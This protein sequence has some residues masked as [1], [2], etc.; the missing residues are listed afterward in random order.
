MRIGCCLVLVTDIVTDSRRAGHPPIRA[1]ILHSG[2]MA[3][4]A[5]DDAKLQKWLYSQVYKGLVDGTGAAVIDSAPLLIVAGDGFAGS[6]GFDRCVASAAEAS[7][8]VLSHI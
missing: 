2:L 7:G 8:H 1:R 5:P 3:G 6:S 4:F